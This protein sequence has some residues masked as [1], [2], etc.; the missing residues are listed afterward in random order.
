MA[1][2]NISHYLLCLLPMHHCTMHASINLNCKKCSIFPNKNESDV[3]SKLHAISYVLLAVV[4]N[5]R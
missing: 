1:Q 3:K 4:R 2:I 5:S